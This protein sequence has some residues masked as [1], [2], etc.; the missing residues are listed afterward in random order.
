M[1]RFGIYTLALLLLIATGVQAEPLC[2]DEAGAQYGIN[3][4]ILRAIA[5][6]E[7][8]YNPRAINRNTNGT[9]DFGVMQINSIW[10]ATLGKERWNA[11]GDPCT[12]IKTGGSIL[13]GCMKK[14]GY[15]WEAIG[16]YN[17]QTPNKRD[18]YAKMVFTQLQRIARDDKKVKLNLEAVV[19][20]QASDWITASQNGQGEKFKVIIPPN[21]VVSSEDSP[22]TADLPSGEQPSLSDAS[23][24]ELRAASSFEGAPSGM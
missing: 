12:N 16:C 13:A 4:Q 5:K 17:S 3:P 6:V 19:R 21:V 20:A 1:A 14:Y 15:T 18:K 8:N 11:L 2:F 24:V 22:E 10:A 23:R 7:S 9:Y